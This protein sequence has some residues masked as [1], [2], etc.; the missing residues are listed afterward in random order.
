MANPQQLKVVVWNQYK[1]ESLSD[2]DVD[3]STYEG[4]LKAEAIDNSS[5]SSIM[6]F[7]NREHLNEHLTAIYNETDVQL[8]YHVLEETPADVPVYDISQ[9]ECGHRQFF[10]RLND[11]T[12]LDVDYS[13]AGKYSKLYVDH[14]PTIGEDSF[15]ALCINYPLLNETH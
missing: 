11:G 13:S 15:D 3:C 12:L 7:M 1:A 8:K 2:A 10:I 9:L 4:L 14:R 5:M 6:T